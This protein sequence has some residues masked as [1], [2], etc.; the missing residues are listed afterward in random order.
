MALGAA[1]CTVRWRSVYTPGEGE[2]WTVN[3]GAAYLDGRVFRGTGDGRLIALDAATGTPLWNVKVGDPRRGEAVPSAPVAWNGLVF[4]GLAV[5]DYGTRGRVMAFDATSGREVW[6]FDTVPS[7][8]QIG[9]DSWASAHSALTGGGAVWSTYT[10][11]PDRGELYV[12]VANPAPAYAPS[13]RPGDNL[14]TDSL[15]VLDARTGAL[16]WW[17]QLIPGDTH[18]WDLGAAAALYRDHKGRDVAIVG[19]K[20]G[21]VYAIDRATHR[22]EFKSP[23]TTISNTGAPL[24]RDGVFV[25]P[26]DLGGMEWNG[27][28]FDPSRDAIYVGSVDWCAIYKASGVIVTNG[29]PNMGGHAER[30]GAATG[31]VTA[32]DALTGKELWRYHAE[33]PVVAGVSPTGGGLVFTADLDGNFL[34]LDA[35]TGK[36]L[37]KLPIGGSVAGGVITYE[38]AGRQYVATTSGNISKVT[39]NASAGSPTI[40]IMAVD[41]PAAVDRQVDAGAGIGALTESV[42]GQAIYGRYCASCHGARGE[43][44]TGPR[45]VGIGARSGQRMIE[46]QI[47]KPRAIMPRLYPGSLSEADVAAVATYV[48]SF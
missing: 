44:A 8:R 38:V 41:G 17:Y 4:A 5:G 13:F 30:Q 46:A 43:G 10:I 42:A 2:P 27:P 28:S 15:V 16:K 21:Y 18:D 24:T 37:L 22:L 36:P 45:L 9:A 47:E 12:S 6:R 32:L 20:D 26:G 1:D 35:R 7:G 11:D 14:F 29:Q 33:A 19:G 23:V 34:A 3:R 25:C 48:A 39:F 40:V 31:W